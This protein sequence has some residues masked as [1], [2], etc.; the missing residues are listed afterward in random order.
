MNESGGR[1]PNDL[2]TRTGSPPPPTRIQS[3]A[4]TGLL[5]LAVC[6]TL[7]FAQQILMPI[8]ASV[9]LALLLQ[10]AVRVLVRVKVPAALAAGIV[11]AA[12]FAVISAGI[13][14]LSDPAAQWM[15]QM[16]NVLAEVQDKI[17]GPIEEIKDVKKEVESFVEEAQQDETATPTPAP[18][19]NKTIE[20]ELPQVPPQTIK[21]SLLEVFT[22]SFAILSNVGWSAV[23]IFVLLYFLL[24]TSRVLRENLVAALSSLRDKKRALAV[25]S[26]VQ[27]DISAYLATVIL[28]NIGLGVAIGLAMHITGLPNGALWGAMAATLNF[29]PYL[30]PV[31]GAFVVA[32][33]GLVTFDTPVQALIPPLIYFGINAVEGNFF[34]PM[35][36]S[37]RLTINP[38]AVFLSVVFWAWIW[39]VPGALMAVPILACLKVI[40]DANERL[41][42]VSQLLNGH[43]Q[44]QS[45]AKTD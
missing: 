12:L 44:R 13:Y 6:Y 38:A 10:P 8:M 2:T 4:T 41:V 34:T 25:T 19:K 37:R 31:A 23:V 20:P 45:L 21:L 11:V 32:I 1:P 36:L 42:P 9:I 7:H 29:I 24:A 5:V 17:K 14:V 43:Q 26:K 15:S 30:G 39:G 27:T 3:F 35:I 16:P 18:D 28:I 40:C 33:V 22:Q